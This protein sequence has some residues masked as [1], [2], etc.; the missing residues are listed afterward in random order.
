V[1]VATGLIPALA[2]WLLVQVET[3]LR[4]AGVTL[5]STVD[6]F[7]PS[8][9]IRGVIALS[10]GFL[11]TSILYAGITAFV[12]DGKFRAATSWLLVA[13]ALSAFGLI[14]SY[15]LTT[16]GVENQFAWFTA[17]PEFSIGYGVAALI[18]FLIPKRPDGFGIAPA[19]GN[20]Y[21]SSAMFRSR[22][23]RHP[24]SPGFVR[25]RDNPDQAVNLD[26]LVLSPGLWQ[27]TPDSFMKAFQTAGFVWTSATKESARA[28]GRSVPLVLL[29]QPAGEDQSF[30]AGD[31]PKQVQVSIHNR[32][33]NGSIEE[34]AYVE[35]IKQVS[36]ALTQQTKVAAIDRG[37]DNKSATR[38]E[39]Y[40]W[41]TATTSFL[42]EFSSQKEIKSKGIP[43]RSG[44]HPVACDSGRITGA[45]STVETGRVTRADLPP[46]SFGR[47][48]TPLSRACRWSIRRE[49]LLRCRRHR[50]RL[51][52]LWN[53][54]GPARDR[55]D[56]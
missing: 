1:A 7:A 15:R 45:G 39:G 43:F 12:I 36:T 49:G 26:P 3:T 19:S 6:Q 13:A 52:V 24:A 46:T 50:P 31:K 42:L 40:L 14:H 5:E 29:G 8:L 55:P 38:A 33:D 11:L 30:F 20:R 53:A 10:Q 23:L 4:V 56:R 41:N 37:K 18:V 35:L 54:S 25:L 22:L 16:N 48:E 47:T 27:A 51:W 21:A 9:Y 2:A 44:I 28:D 32:G 34:E 17:A